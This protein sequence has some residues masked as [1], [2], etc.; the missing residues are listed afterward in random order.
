MEANTHVF[1]LERRGLKYMCESAKIQLPALLVTNT[2]SRR[3]SVAASSAK[4]H[5]LSSYRLYVPNFRTLS[6]SL[7]QRNVVKLLSDILDAGGTYCFFERTNL[8]L[9]GGAFHNLPNNSP[10]R[11]TSIKLAEENFEIRF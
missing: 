10:R 11:G 8:H 6:P 1:S 7:P 4:S 5:F 3:H 2:P 9:C